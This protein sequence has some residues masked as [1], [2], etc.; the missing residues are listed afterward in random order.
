[1]TGTYEWADG[2]FNSSPR[3]ATG[4]TELLATKPYPVSRVVR[5]HYETRAS[6]I[7]NFHQIALNI[8]RLALNDELHPAVL[9]W[10]INETPDSLG[11]SYHRKLEDRHFTLPVFFRTDEVTPGRIIEIQCPG[12]AWGEL[13]IAYEYAARLG[14]HVGDSSPADQFATQL[15]NFLKESPVAEHLL[16]NSSAPSGMRYF[17]EKTRPRV[18]YCNID[19]G[20]RASDC[21]FIRSHA[22]YSICADKEFVPRLA[23]VGRG[24]TYDLPPHILFDNKAVF[25]LPFWSLTRAW[26]PDDIRA[27]FPFTTPLLPDGIEFPDGKCVTIEEFSRLPQS[28]RSYF[29][30]YAGASLALNWGSRAVYRLSNLGSGAC[31]EFLRQCLSGYERG[32]IWLLQKE[33]AQEDEIEY[34]TRDGTV[35]T[36]R[37]RAKFSGYYGPGGCLGVLVMHRR[38]FK[39]HGQGE[40]VLSYVL[41]DGEE[42]IPA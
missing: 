29:L 20:I 28:Q 3:Y 38:H 19:H 26:F 17:I 5:H 10:L 22:F 18:K 34:Q 24:V 37:M 42:N 30:K 6:L 8:F 9:H 1:M 21:N 31:L 2:L 11:I 35:L 12:S 33:E 32:Q 13:Q 23:K 16:D 15:T 40:T 4:F 25:V 14:Y 36:Q 27:L 39:V 41:A 7:Q